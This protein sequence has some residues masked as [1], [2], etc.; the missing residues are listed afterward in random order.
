MRYLKDEVIWKWLIFIDN[1][2]HIHISAKTVLYKQFRVVE[3]NQPKI[4]IFMTVA[5][6]RFEYT[7]LLIEATT[8]KYVS[9][10]F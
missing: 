9:F 4:S 1:N 5:V 3:K 6:K 8:N 7:F 10:F 2:N